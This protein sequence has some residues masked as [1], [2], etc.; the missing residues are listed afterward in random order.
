MTDERKVNR[1]ALFTGLFKGPADGA[2]SV[3]SGPQP[4][5]EGRPTHAPSGAVDPTPDAEPAPDD[6]G[7]AGPG[8][9]P[10]E[11]HVAGPGETGAIPAETVEPVEPR[12]ARIQPAAC[13]AYRGSFCTVCVERCPEPGAITSE[14][15]RPTIVE[16]LC[17]GCGE[18]VS[19]CPAPITAI[20][21]HSIR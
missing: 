16:D 20:T 1:R 4:V 13:I 7:E 17:T 9:E 5:L 15:G 11:A 12:V 3:G 19:R 10:G 21:T 8:A 2:P 18:C 6:V 14:Y